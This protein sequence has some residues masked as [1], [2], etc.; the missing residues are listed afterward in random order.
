MSKYL[1]TTC[2]A[3]SSVFPTYVR[4]HDVKTLTVEPLYHVY[5]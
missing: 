2:A 1:S 4:E 5:S 3:V